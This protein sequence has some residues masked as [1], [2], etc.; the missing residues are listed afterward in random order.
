MTSHL[1]VR[2]AFSLLMATTAVPVP[3]PAAARVEPF[4]VLLS[5]ELPDTATVAEAQ[6]RRH[7][8]ALDAVYGAIKGYRAQLSPEAVRALESDPRVVAMQRDEPL[9]LPV[10]EPAAAEPSA[11]ARAAAPAQQLPTGVNR[12]DGELSSTRSGDGRGSV[13]A[14]IAILDTGIHRFHP[15]LNVVG[16]KDCLG[17]GDYGDDEGHGTHVAGTAAARDNAIGVVGV[18]PGARL[19]SVRV[20]DENREGSL[21]SLLCGVDWVTLNAG[22]I[23]VANMSI[24]GYASEPAATGCATGDALHDAICRSVTAGVVYTVAAGNSGFDASG[25]VPAA[26]DEVITVSALTDLDGKPGGTAAT[27]CAAAGS[28]RDDTFAAYSN[29]GDDITV[30]APGTCIRSTSNEGASYATRSGT[31]MAAAHVAGAAALHL[32]LHPA[33]TPD[34]VRRALRRAATSAWNSTDDRD[35]EKEPLVNVDAL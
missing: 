9:R 29:F 3:A 7:G 19:W 13:N 4:V 26:Y 30:I 14:D 28:D 27:R 2:A 34:D 1:L 31:S 11:L 18:A 8:F 5:P 22:R 20:L 10:E 15:D 33:A 6:A 25:A 12:V 23:D 16:G 17:A 24:E 35:P 21:S 32:S